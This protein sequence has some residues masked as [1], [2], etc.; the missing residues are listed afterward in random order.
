MGFAE[1]N[2]VVNKRRADPGREVLGDL[3]S[4]LLAGA[5]ATGAGLGSAGVSRGRAE[6]QTV[7]CEVL[8]GPE[9]RQAGGNQVRV[10]GVR[11]N[12]SA[13]K[14]GV[15]IRS[16]CS[17]QSRVSSPLPVN[18]HDTRR[19]SLRRLTPPHCAARRRARSI[20]PAQRTPPPPHA[21]VVIS[22]PLSAA[23]SVC[24][25]HGLLFPCLRLSSTSACLTLPSH[26]CCL[27]TT[28]TPQ[29]GRPRNGFSVCSRCHVLL[30]R[31]FF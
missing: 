14:L 1:G 24:I 3:G 22:H 18:V 7:F 12:A 4:P 20:H 13:M 6:Q 2:T 28:E 27:K 30:R 8:C 21:R 25:F 23:L 29:E 5:A 26:G 9:S 17:R 11:A 19:L 10:C 15:Y 31:L 16:L